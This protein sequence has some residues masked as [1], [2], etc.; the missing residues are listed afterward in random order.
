MN[1]IGSEIRVCT[2]ICLLQQGF[3]EM[4]NC[5]FSDLDF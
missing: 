3:N 2:K 5:K 4:V 1:D